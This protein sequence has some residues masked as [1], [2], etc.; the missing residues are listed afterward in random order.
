MEHDIAAAASALSTALGRG[1]AAAAAALYAAEG[2]MLTPAAE[3]IAGRRE[4][5]AYWRAG[6]DVG[7]TGVEL[8]TIELQVAPGIAVELGRYVLAS[9]A[10]TPE[11]G[12]YVV[13]HRQEADGSWR[14]LVDVFNPDAPETA[15]PQSK[16]ER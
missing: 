5:E 10:G 16:E 13:L 6:L 8:E 2:R 1:D 7:L 9:A 11:A 12:K 3:L 15:R 4:I 14:R